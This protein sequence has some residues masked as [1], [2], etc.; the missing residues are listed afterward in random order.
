MNR[1]LGVATLAVV[2]LGLIASDVFAGNQ[3]RARLKV[4]D[5]TVGC[6][7]DGDC[8]GTY[9]RTCT[10]NCAESCNQDCSGI[11][12]HDRDRDRDH[13]WENCDPELQMLL[14]WLGVGG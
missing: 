12:Q 4:Q 3:T 6:C 14:L 11:Q 2:V 7:Q 13:D 9:D 8:T 10:R 5:C 1:V